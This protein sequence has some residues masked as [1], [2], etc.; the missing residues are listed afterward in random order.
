MIILQYQTR[1]LFPSVVVKHALMFYSSPL[2]FIPKRI[3]NL[4]EKVKTFYL[5]Q[6][7]ML[8][9]LYFFKDF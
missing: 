4:Q 5:C 7:K 3:L 1:S 9:V 6:K 8:K 2:R